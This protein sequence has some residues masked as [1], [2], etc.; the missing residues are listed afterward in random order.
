MMLTGVILAGGPNSG[1]DGENKAFLVLDH[2]PLI[3]RQVQEMKKVC[4]EI[5]VVTNDPVPF[6]KTLD[7]DIRIITDY[8]PKKGPLSGMYSGLTLANYKHSW[9]VSCDMPFLSAAAAK[10]MLGKIQPGLEAVIPS[11]NKKEYLLH[12]LY[13]KSCAAAILFLLEKGE[14]RLGNLLKKMMVLRVGEAE[15]EEHGVD[16]RF[17]KSMDT[18]KDY[19][20]I[21]AWYEAKRNQ[22]LRVG[23]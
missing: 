20:T 3:K 21:V 13:D 4:Q 2:V 12:G 9:V 14:P 7:R 8:Y 19:E 15:F 23:L 22:Y 18:R 5:I 1:M 6:L 10:Y 11:F 16:C 17:V